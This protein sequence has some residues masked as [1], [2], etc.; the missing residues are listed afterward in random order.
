VT[1]Q[2]AHPHT[3]MPN[4]SWN[5]VTSTTQERSIINYHRTSTRK[6]SWANCMHLKQIH[7]KVCIGLHLSEEFQL[8]TLN[9]VKQNTL[10]HHSFSTLLQNMALGRS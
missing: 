7:S 3:T 9:D 5:V 4:T 2:A 6:A 1:D 8:P 10:Y